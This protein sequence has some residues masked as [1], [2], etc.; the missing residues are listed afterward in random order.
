MKQASS[1]PRRRSQQGQPGHL[2]KFPS[3][4]PTTKPPEETPSP[5]ASALSSPVTSLSEH[6]ALLQQYRDRSTSPSRASPSRSVITPPQ[7]ASTSDVPRDAL[8][9]VRAKARWRKARRD[10]LSPCTVAAL[11]TGVAAVA[12]VVG[13]VLGSP[14]A[15]EGTVSEVAE[16]V[17]A[18]KGE[19]IDR[20]PI[21]VSRRQL[22]MALKQSNISQKKTTLVW[23]QL[24]ESSGMGFGMRCLH[25]ILIGAVPVLCFLLVVG[26][27]LK[28]WKKIKVCCAVR[29]EGSLSFP[30][31]HI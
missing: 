22:E 25:C 28:M 2:F 10:G 29:R 26:M 15:V 4:P 3:P 30:Q 23:E 16:Q 31:Y 9:L 8:E 19:I 21:F 14:G 5:R 17:S 24:I 7:E 6:R 27:V 18:V 13:I 1:S 12:F 11:A 20:L